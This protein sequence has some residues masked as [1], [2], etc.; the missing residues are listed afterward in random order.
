M[1]CTRCGGTGKGVVEGLVDLGG[2]CGGVDFG[3]VGASCS[4]SSPGGDAVTNSRRELS[5]AL[6]QLS[7]LFAK[8]EK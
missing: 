4:A 7:L 6:L 3:E 5:D 8:D 1:E 2:R